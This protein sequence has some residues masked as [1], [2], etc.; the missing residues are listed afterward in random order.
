MEIILNNGVEFYYKEILVDFFKY[1]IY[2]RIKE[3]VGFFIVFDLSNY[4]LIY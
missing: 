4:I 3:L 1:F 2:N